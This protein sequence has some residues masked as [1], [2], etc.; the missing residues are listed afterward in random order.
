MQITYEIAYS[1]GR[2]AGNRSMRAAGRAAWNETDW[3]AA[4]TETLRL[5]RFGGF[6]P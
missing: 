1:L 3:N 5:L 6:A 2:D 4:S